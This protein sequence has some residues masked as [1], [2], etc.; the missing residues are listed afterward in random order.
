[1]P[2]GEVLTSLSARI[3]ELSDAYGLAVDPDAYIYDL[4]VGQQQRVE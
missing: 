2:A 4:S 3:R 1:M